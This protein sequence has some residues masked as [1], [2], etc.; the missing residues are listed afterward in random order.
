MSR[1]DESH[2]ASLTPEALRDEIRAN[3][4]AERRLLVIGAVSAG[5]T[6]VLV[7]LR[8]LA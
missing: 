3:A 6:L 4:R 8:A 5:V 2:W 1:S 7:L